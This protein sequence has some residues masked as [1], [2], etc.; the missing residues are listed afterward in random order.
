MRM[1]RTISSSPQP[2]AGEN[3]AITARGPAQLRPGEMLSDLKV[4]EKAIQEGATTRVSKGVVIDGKFIP[5]VI[6]NDVKAGEHIDLK[7]EFVNGQIQL[8]YLQRTP[9]PAAKPQDLSKQLLESL[10]KTL[11][12]NH[13]T[14]ETLRNVFIPLL[15]K[16][17]ENAK[18]LVIPEVLKKLLQ[19]NR[20][21]EFKDLKSADKLKDILSQSR[22]E[23]VGEQLS[24]IS[25]LRAGPSAVSPSN[26]RA[27]EFV[28]LILRELNIL[29]LD[30][31]LKTKGA[32]PAAKT[33]EPQAKDIGAMLRNLAPRFESVAHNE[34]AGKLLPIFKD[35]ITSQVD[36]VKTFEAKIKLL[37]SD[38]NNGGSL[39]QLIT[40]LEQLKKETENDTSP[41]GRLLYN[42]AQTL[43]SEIEKALKL[44]DSAQAIKLV[45]EEGLKN[46]YETFKLTPLLMRFS[47]EVD[48]SPFIPPQLKGSLRLIEVQL[49]LVLGD[50]NFEEQLAEL[51]QD[52]GK[53]L[54]L[55]LQHVQLEVEKV[56][57]Q[58]P[59][60]AR[61]PQL[62][63]AFER[64]QE[65][66]RILT[67]L[68][69]P[70]ESTPVPTA[71]QLKTVL[72]NTRL[73]LVQALQSEVGESFISVL[74]TAE[75]PA[76]VQRIVKN[77]ERAMVEMLKL[78]SLP[79]GENS[80]KEI[81]K[82]PGLLPYQALKTFLKQ[83]VIELPASGSPADDAL[84]ESSFQ[85]IDQIEKAERENMVRSAPLKESAQRALSQFQRFLNSNQPTDIVEQSFNQ[86]DSETLRRVGSL[87]ASQEALQRMM[88]MMKTLGE[89]ALMLFPFI[90]GNLMHKAQM[91]F[92][93]PTE[94]E[95]E[96]NPHRNGEAQQLFSR[97][98]LLIPLPGMGRV[99]VDVAYRP[100]EMLLNLGFEQQSVAEFI[101][102]KTT[103]L[104][105]IF[106]SIGYSKN[107]ISIVTLGSDW[108][109]AEIIQDSPLHALLDRSNLI[110]G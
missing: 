58:N 47:S 92:Y 27:L 105:R 65:T 12:L 56:I 21:P 96:A 41:I 32:D 22:P 91:S 104:R 34:E 20:V 54:L 70:E 9:E 45:L 49:I 82:N 55:K 59:V 106:N 2:A 66:R 38:N 79:Q 109:N 28:R 16:S 15:S 71:T 78:E 61:P 84:L 62:K 25:K 101:E 97:I 60:E 29:K 50:A 6:P 8:R 53:G 63:E 98:K 33:P 19:S 10:L 85:L 107:Q 99:L 42:F 40:A 86:V 95:R 83:L 48:E 26:S 100:G 90:V 110:A 46:L 3:I 14:S 103:E 4:V 1:S 13:Q 17:E 80:L 76:I 68:I 11:N 52:R 89:P 67:Q 31:P 5:V 73:A 7:V 74:S 108:N 77:I 35:L 93:S 39:S 94:S 64:L 72:E 23:H 51:H 75:R 30:A 102:T 81:V 18:P 24:T 88:P 57:E 87:V 37:L 36:T 43:S 44:P 69:Q